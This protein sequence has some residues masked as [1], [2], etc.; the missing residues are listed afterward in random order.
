MSN[1]YTV[2][3]APTSISAATVDLIEITAAD[4]RPI[5]ILG[6]RAWQTTDFGDAQDEIVGLKWVRGNTTSGSGGSAAA[7]GVGKTGREP[8]SGFQ[9]EAGN[10]T[11][12]SGGTA[13]TPYSTGK[14]VRGPVEITLTEKQQFGTDQGLGLLVLRL[15]AAPVDAITLAVS[16]DVEELP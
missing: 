6:F 16:V 12:A 1:V 4:D 11:A 9:F 14:N 10:T 13:V 7:S 2:E 5:R 3:L 8:A 15:A